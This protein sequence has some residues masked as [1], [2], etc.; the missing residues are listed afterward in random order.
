MS[1][2]LCFNRCGTMVY[3]FLTLPPLALTELS[4][5]RG[6]CRCMEWSMTGQW[7][8]GCPGDGVVG[9]AG[10]YELVF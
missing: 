3:A 9:G 10:L 1:S 2:V 7:L 4:S 6:V 5:S 8:Y